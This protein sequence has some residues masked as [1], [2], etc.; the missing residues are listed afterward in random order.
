M[1]IF[2]RIAI[3]KEIMLSGGSALFQETSRNN[4]HPFVLVCRL[5]EHSSTQCLNNARCKAHDSASVRCLCL[6][7]SF[8]NNSEAMQAL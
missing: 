1:A 2:D 7:M 3:S 8:L 6:D 5:T 4:Q